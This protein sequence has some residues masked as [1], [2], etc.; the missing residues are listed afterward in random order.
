M[1]KLT[2]DYVK[3]FIEGNK[4]YKLLSTDYTGI[5]DKN[6]IIKCNNNHK[7]TTTFCGFQQGNRC[8]ECAGNKKLTYE[9]VKQ[10][11]ESVNYKLLSKVYNNSDSNLKV[12]CDNN[13]S[14]YYVSFTTFKHGHRCAVCANKKKLTYEYVKHYI[15]KVEGYK[16]LSNDYTGI[17][18]KNL[19]IQCDKKHQ[20]YLV[21]FDHFKNDRRC[22]FCAV[23]RSKISQELFKHI[24]EQIPIDLDVY[25]YDS[26][27]E[28][29][30]E[31]NRSH[32][33]L[34]FYI[35]SLNKCIEFNGEYWHGFPDSEAKDYIRE[36]EIKEVL[37]DI[38]F[39]YVDEQDYRDFPD[40]VIIDCLQHI[41]L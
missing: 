1:R 31:T 38:D 37:P 13:H 11:I 12:Q 25:Y 41:N 24:H 35:P 5:H 26:K 9:Y 3:D 4:G 28:Y 40:K 17:H 32:R 36:Q 15:E 39:W 29:R 23:K 33:M 2:Y 21:S 22:P 19:L 8:S 6:L 20:C 7:Y 30:V 16:L 10:Y 34:D 18:D 27:H 14:Q